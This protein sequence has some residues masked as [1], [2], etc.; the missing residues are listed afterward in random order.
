MDDS[1]SRV[2]VQTGIQAVGYVWIVIQVSLIF[3]VLH[4]PHLEVTIQSDSDRQTI[5]QKN[6]RYTRRK[7]QNFVGSCDKKICSNIYNMLML[8]NLWVCKSDTLFLSSIRTSS[9]AAGLCCRQEQNCKVP[10]FLA[11]AG[12]HYW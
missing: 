5:L 4:I 12:V 8:S 7:L 9:G 1:S 2:V 3:I 6:I 10:A 11:L